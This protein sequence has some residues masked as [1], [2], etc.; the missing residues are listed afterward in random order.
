[1]KKKSTPVR[2]NFSEGGFFNLRALFGL[3]V[4][5]TG[6]SLAHFA[7][8]PLGRSSSPSSAKVA[9]QQQNYKVD[10]KPGREPLVHAAFDCFNIHQHGNDKQE[11]LRAK[12]TM[13]V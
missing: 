5:M 12:A 10:T 3:C 2:R 8:N 9:Q 11:N 4:G 13:T 6:I 1:M 7:A